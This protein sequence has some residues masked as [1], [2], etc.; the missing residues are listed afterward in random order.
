M[1]KAHSHYVCQQCGYES[2]GWL[3]K[4]PNCDSWGSLVETISAPTTIN[5]TVKNITSSKPVLLSS[6]K[7]QLPL[8]V[9]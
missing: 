5:S 4:C 3:G 8:I 9:Q 2:T 7:T 6:I 1:A